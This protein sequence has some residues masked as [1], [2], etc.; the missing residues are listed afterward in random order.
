M[1]S[2][3]NA[4]RRDEVLGRALREAADLGATGGEVDFEAVYTAAGWRDSA[5][6][7]RG[8]AGSRGAAPRL[9]FVGSSR[10]AP[11][12]GLVGGSRAL[13]RRLALALPLAAAASLAVGLG[14]GQ[15]A[16]SRGFRAEIALLSRRVVGPEGWTAT[17]ALY[18]VPGG[19]AAGAGLADDAAAASW[20]YGGSAGEPTE[21]GLFVEGLWSQ[22]PAAWGSFGEDYR[23]GDE[24]GG[25]AGEGTTAAPG[26]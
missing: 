4:D 3:D 7:G 11:R 18:R 9:G 14:L 23:D 19:L 1:K 21:L 6:E 17:E 8:L 22:G 24:A 15:A 5:A 2:G 16:R 25:D 12:S 26:L 13:G 20:R 10:A